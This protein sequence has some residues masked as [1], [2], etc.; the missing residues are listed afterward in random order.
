MIEDKAKTLAELFVEYDRWKNLFRK[1]AMGNQ[2]A[3]AEARDTRKYFEEGKWVLLE[4][5]QQDHK[6]IYDDLCDEIRKK[7]E[8]K[9]KLV[10]FCDN[11]VVILPKSVK[12]EE[13]DM[14]TKESWIIQTADPTEWSMFIDSLD[15]MLVKVKA[16]LKDVDS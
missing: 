9:Q 2:Q 12:I 6:E 15:G 16:L 14:K 4:D 1:G 5:A 8:L 13:Y 10:T 11:L 3:Y 7:V